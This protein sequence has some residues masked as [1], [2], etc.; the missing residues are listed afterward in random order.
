MFQARLRSIPLL[1]LRLYHVFKHSEKFPLDASDARVNG[2][3]PNIFKMANA[4]LD[5]MSLQFHD[6]AFLTLVLKPIYSAYA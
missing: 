2:D 4:K 5:V 3:L 6:Y 1:W